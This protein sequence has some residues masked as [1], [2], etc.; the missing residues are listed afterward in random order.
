MPKKKQKQEVNSVE[1]DV[2]SFE[3]KLD[4]IYINYFKPV[5]VEKN[6][7]YGNAALEP[8]DFLNINP[9]SYGIIRSRLNE[10]LNRLHSLASLDESNM[11]EEELQSNSAAIEDSIMDIA[12]YWFLQSIEVVGLKLKA[13]QL[14]A[15][16]QKN[17][18]AKSK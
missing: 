4:T 2:A 5:L 10:K 11:S 18:N 15:N 3:T 7:Q 9:Q 12:G 8:I 6:K 14:I 1:W 16:A 13:A 17:T